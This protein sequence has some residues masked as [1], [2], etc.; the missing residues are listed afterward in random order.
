M[1]EALSDVK[2]TLD[3]QTPSAPENLGILAIFIK[4]TET[5]VKTY[6]NPDADTLS[7]DLAGNSTALAA[8]QG[9]VAADDHADKL[10]VIRYKDGE[11]L[12]AHN[13]YADVGYEFAVVAGDSAAADA[14]VL[15][16]AFDGEKSRFVVYPVPATTDTVTKADSIASGFRGTSRAIIFAAGTTTNAAYTAAGNL[17]GTLGNEKVGSITWK[18]KN[19]SAVTPTDL[20][21]GQIKQLHQNKIF[22]YATKAGKAQT[23]EGFTV[24]G[25]F[26]DE[27]HGDDWVKASVESALQ[28]LL[29]DSPKLAYDSQGI[30]SI[31]A[32]ITAVLMEANTNGI[33]LTDA[34]T[35]KGAFEVTTKSRD[36]V[37]Q[38][39]VAT[40]KYSGASFTYR[41]AGAIHEVKVTGTVTL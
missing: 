5:S 1:T 23:T 22:T 3:V 17:V 14:A 40:R 11:I 21:A 4:D 10:V 7:T 25:E 24:S 18:F 41:R 16:N 35:N 20:N 28:K 29:C 27:L 36:E 38:S 39:D 8:A 19:L 15:A 37:A 31:N 34:E 13:T 12:T 6:T 33:I 26:I 9:Y 30:A 32:A 2:V